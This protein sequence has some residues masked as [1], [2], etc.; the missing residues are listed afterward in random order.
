[1]CNNM[2]Q[3]TLPQAQALHACKVPKALCPECQSKTFVK[4]CT[5]FCGHLDQGGSLVVVF[6]ASIVP[7]A[8]SRYLGQQ[9]KRLEQ[10]VS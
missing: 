3:A 9:Q 5:D 2:M 4:R 1:M 7:V 10:T 6:G 8:V